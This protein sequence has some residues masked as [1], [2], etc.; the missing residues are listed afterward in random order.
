MFSDEAKNL[1]CDGMK[2]LQPL[3]VNN[4]PTPQVAAM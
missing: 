2:T 1:L 4:R 3:H